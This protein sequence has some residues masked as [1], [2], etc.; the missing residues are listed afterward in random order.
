MNTFIKIFGAVLLILVVG[1]FA[2]NAY[3]YNEKQA[4]TIQN[5][6]AF[7]AYF[8]EQIV[9]RGVADIG[10]PIEGFSGGLLIQAYPGLEVSDFEGVQTFE[11]HYEVSSQGQLA[12]VRDNEEGPVT[13]AE[14]TVSKEGY[15]TLLENI[16]ARLEVPVYT[17][18]DIDAILEEINTRENISVQIGESVSALGV[19]V[20]PLSIVEDSR[21]PPQVRCVWEGRFVINVRIEDSVESVEEGI[22]KGKPFIFKEREITLHRI[23]PTLFEEGGIDESE[24]LF[25]FIIRTLY[26]SE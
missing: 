7:T 4:E 25:H 6:E 12:F 19:T 5:Q 20:T 9:E 8:Q 11:G 10:M 22:E 3:I 14:T 16:S 21:C 23:E 1:F 2:L 18:E 26:R 15:A 17:L 24:Y 13:S